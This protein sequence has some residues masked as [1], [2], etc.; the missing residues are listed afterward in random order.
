L[1]INKTDGLEPNL[2]LMN[3]KRCG[4]FYLV[5]SIKGSLKKAAKIK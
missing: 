1:V 2:D 3:K 4:K 5:G